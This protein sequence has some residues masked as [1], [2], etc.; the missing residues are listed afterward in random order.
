MF[1]F[2]GTELVI[3]LLV[4]LLVIN[5]KDLPS[6]LRQLRDAMRKIKSTASEFTQALMG[7]EGLSDLKKEADKL[8]NDIRHI[9]DLNGNLQ[10][11]YSLDDIKDDLPRQKDKKESPESDDA[12]PSKK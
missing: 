7:E 8:N 10:P 11:T 6:T 9:V 5:P 4:A 12:T 3:I 2:S 1:G